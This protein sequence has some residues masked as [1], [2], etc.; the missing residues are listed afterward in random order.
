MNPL[1]S[2]MTYLRLILCDSFDQSKGFGVIGCFKMFLKGFPSYCQ[3]F[4]YN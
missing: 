1:N 2:D 3:P 4:V